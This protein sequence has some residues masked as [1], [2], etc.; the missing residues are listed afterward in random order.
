MN[1]ETEVKKQQEETVQTLSPQEF[2]SRLA[3]LVQVAEKNEKTVRQKQ[4]DAAF[5]GMELDDD[6][7]DKISQYLE[8]KGIDIV[9]ED[10]ESIGEEEEEQITDEE[11]G[12]ITSEIDHQAKNTDDASE[13]DLEEI[14]R[15]EEENPDP[16]IV[17]DAVSTE[18][19][20]RMYLKEIGRIS[21]LKPDQ[22]ISLAKRMETGNIASDILDT[23]FTGDDRDTLTATEEMVRS[24]FELPAPE[25]G[26][27]DHRE[28]EYQEKI[29]LIAG[30]N[31][32]ELGYL[33]ADGNDARNS[34]TE[35]NLRL[36]VSVAKKY[37]NHGMSFLD[38]IQEG[39][40][41]LIKAVDKFEFRKGFKFSTYATWWIRQAITRAI[42]DQARTIRV[43]VHMVETVN[44]LN[45]IRRQ[46][47]VDL[48]R[49]PTDEELAKAPIGE[50][51]DSSVGD[52][53]A[54][55]SS[56]SPSEAA[57]YM[58]MQQRIEE[59]LGTLT[60]R[61]QQVLRMRF[62]LNGGEAHT[63]EEVGE[64]FG[65][66][67]ERIRQI[68]AKALR[69]LRHPSRGKK[70]R[71]FIEP[72]TGPCC[73]QGSNGREGKGIGMAEGR[74][75]GSKPHRPGSTH[76]APGAFVCSD[77]LTGR[78]RPGKGRKDRKWEGKNI[79]KIIDQE[80]WKGWTFV[81]RNR[82][83]EGRNGSLGT[84]R[85]VQKGSMNRNQRSV[86]AAE[87]C[88]KLSILS[89]YP[90]I[91]FSHLFAVTAINLAA[92]IIATHLSISQKPSKSAMSL[93][94]QNG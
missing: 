58:M 80:G 45:R 76:R 12:T 92:K 32:R 75:R 61:E 88:H 85:A 44:R 16:E 78:E 24:V 60:E 52:F 55:T 28:E 51:D 7:Q 54:D 66:T 42:A 67:R 43:P 17:P 34:L 71:D 14:E 20:V 68:E 65:V 86:L 35:A 63:L 40:M 84:A 25:E 62:G 93:T 29:S 39:N 91:T 13:E 36:V 56:M 27:E 70:L 1:K 89:Q 9:E 10:E 53:V 69:K 2:A 30:K 21:L 19:P 3:A 18:D 31:K 38:L 23:C 48:G 73:R 64:V 15:Q 5:H 83:Q 47:T 8:S 6:I 33:V 81:R 37:V 50:E 90:Q 82:G 49:D 72:E 79:R 74:H 26:A 41:G 87:F 77:F 59:V 22:E 46:L 57:T 94:L 11:L 4:I